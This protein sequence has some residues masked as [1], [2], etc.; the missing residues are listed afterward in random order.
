MKIKCGKCKGTNVLQEAS[1]MVNPNKE[2][3]WD[4]IDLF[5][6]L[7]WEDY[8]YCEDCGDETQAEE[9]EE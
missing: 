1:I 9:T 6:S 3:E 5:D 8:Y 2:G 4:K 7:R